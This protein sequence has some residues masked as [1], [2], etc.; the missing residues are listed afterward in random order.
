MPMHTTSLNDHFIT[1]YII[2]YNSTAQHIQYRFSFFMTF[3][4]SFPS[5]GV[6]PLLFPLALGDILSETVTRGSDIS[7]RIRRDRLVRCWSD[8]WSDRCHDV[9]TA[10]IHSRDK[11]GI[12]IVK[13]W[14]LF[15]GRY[16]WFVLWSIIK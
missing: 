4:F 2:K 1:N 9:A 3:P 6:R 5:M 8:H 12:H 14:P 10:R 11:I 16:P 7:R 15:Q 13:M